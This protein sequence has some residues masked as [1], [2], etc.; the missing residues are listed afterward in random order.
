MNPAE[1]EKSLIARYA[2]IENLQERLAA[3]VERARKLPALRE[4]ERIDLHRVPG[5]VS[6]V[7]LIGTLEEGRCRFRLDADSTLVKALASL[8]CEVYDAAVPGD[9]VSYETQVLEVL[10]LSENL[11]PTRRHGL[12]Q[13]RRA[14]Q[15]WAAGAQSRLV[16]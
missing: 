9:I 10:R 11:S 12:V 6:R 3:V 13:V 8:I 1:T 2:I 16:P 7:W 15:A 14:I 5:C 4:D